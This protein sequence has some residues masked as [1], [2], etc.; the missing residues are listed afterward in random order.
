MYL[1]SRCY[2]IVHVWKLMLFAEVIMS[3]WDRLRKGLPFSKMFQTLYSVLKQ[4]NVLELSYAARIIIIIIF[5]ITYGE[6]TKLAVSLFMIKRDQIN[7]YL[8]PGGFISHETHI[9]IFIFFFRGDIMDSILNES[10]NYNNN[11][12]VFYTIT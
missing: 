6:N 7:K 4:T 8:Q 1:Y 3:V 11:T 5:M 10:Y 12:I 9:H 2:A